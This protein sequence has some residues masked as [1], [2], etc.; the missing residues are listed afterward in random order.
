MANSKAIKFIR[1]K[2]YKFIK[3]IGQGGLG[4]T[5]LIEDEYIQEQFICKKFSPIYEDLKTEYFKNFVEEVRLM[6][7]L[8]HKNIVRVF[9]YYMYPELKTGYILMEYVHGLDI[10]KYIIANPDKIEDIFIQTIEGFM[11]LEEN[12]I[13][14]R[15][16]RPQNILVSHDG[17]VKIIDFG[18]GKQI[19]FN[20]QYD[21]S[22][23]LNWR[24]SQPSEFLEKKYDFKTE[25][26]F[27]GKL[28]EEIIKDNDLSIRFDN[29]LKK[30]I[31]LNPVYRIPSF[32]DVSREL[33]RIKS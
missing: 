6:H 1:Q 8:Y 17:F 30:M 4:K 23:S 32:F 29:T 22:V 5:I 25:I 24:Y 13:L 18:F 19:N 16:I 14:H 10:D 11:Y 21:K 15:D 28:F 27:I 7:L 33:M 12:K 20:E 2:D 31:I 26:Y 3:N 9:N